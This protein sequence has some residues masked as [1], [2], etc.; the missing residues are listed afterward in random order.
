MPEEIS[1]GQ[2]KAEMLEFKSDVM[3]FQTVVTKFIEVAN[4]KFDGL[5]ADVRSNTFKLDRLENGL[6]R[7]EERVDRVEGKVDRVETNLKAVASDLKVLSG[8]FQDVAVMAMKDKARIDTLEKRV[9]ERE[10]GI[11]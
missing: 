7:V 11:H 2:F 8:Q 3:N 4:Q 6:Q 5:T 10:S 9:D 1:D